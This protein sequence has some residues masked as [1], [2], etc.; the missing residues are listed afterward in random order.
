MREL[1]NEA[2]EI[3]GIPQRSEEP[4]SNA[5]MEGEFALDDPAEV[6]TTPDVTPFDPKHLPKKT[7]A[8]NDN[9]A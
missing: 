7:G 3:S 4:A 9:E 8:K 1:L 6:N 5:P 2:D